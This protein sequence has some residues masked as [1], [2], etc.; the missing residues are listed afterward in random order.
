M[1]SAILARV[2]LLI[3]LV[4]LSGCDG[5]G[6]QKTT[7]S[8]WAF[9][10]EG[11]AVQELVADFEQEHPDIRVRVQQIPWSAAHEKLLTAFAGDSMPDLFQL[12]NT[13]LPEFVAFGAVADLGPRLRDAEDIGG[14]AFFAGVADTNVID[15]V[16]YGLPWYV[17]TRL[18]FYRKD[19]LQQAGITEFPETWT[20]WRAAM[21]RIKRQVGDDRYAIFL[22]IDDW[23]T[24]AILALQLGAPLLA[25]DGQFGAFDSPAMHQAMRFYL[26][27]FRD[28]L[29]PSAGGSQVANLYQEFGNGY[30]AQFVSGPWNIGELK[31][32]LP[33]EAALWSTAPMP[34]PDGGDGNGAAS[35][36]GVSLAGGAS[37][38]I[39][40]HS[41]R[42][43]AAWALIR[44]LSGAEQQARFHDLT[45]NLP[46]RK[47]AWRATGLADD[48]HAAAFWRQL[49]HMVPTPKIP[50]WERI[51]RN[52]GRYVEDVIRGDRTIDDALATLDSDVDRMLEKRR[53]MLARDQ[54]G[55]DQ[56]GRIREG[57]NR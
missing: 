25:D 53:W 12:G 26:D 44:F 33:A 37:L 2:L 13:W 35:A 24:P 21:E 18:V 28:G 29:A 34:R 36:P 8:F 23:T 17:D 50:E 54:Q 11:E 10:Q 43:D 49:Q 48:P 14:D 42:Q 31:E 19:I 3:G 7:L 40:A 39:H 4:S 46:A 9:G 52:F 5:G 32:R 20:E 22:P 56:Q 16:V 6:E 41:P 55:P 30:F 1:R 45:G 51:A 38:V 57:T 15:G 47:D 27:L